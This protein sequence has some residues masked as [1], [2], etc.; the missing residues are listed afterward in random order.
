MGLDHGEA[1][2]V[3]VGTVGFE[4]PGIVTDAVD[5]FPLERRKDD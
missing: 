3:V 2:K 5:E 1:S 4:L